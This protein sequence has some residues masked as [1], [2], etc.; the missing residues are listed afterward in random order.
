MKII[1]IVPDGVAVRNFL[2]SNFLDELQKKGFE[3]HVLYQIPEYAIKE[4]N[5]VTNAI[6]EYHR[7]PY[8]TE[9]ALARTLR[10]VGVYARLLHNKKVLHNETI[11]CFWN[12]KKKGF[13]R[14][15]LAKVSE[16]VGFFLSK[17]YSSILFLENY[18]V[19]IMA[20]TKIYNE[21][22]KIIKAINP[23]VVLNLHQRSITSSPI[24]NYCNANNIK[25]ATMIFSWDNVPKAR[26]IS[27]YK[28][29]F[30]WSELM[31]NELKITYNE[32]KDKQ[33]IVTGSPQFECYFDEKIKMTKDDFFKEYN[34]S[35]HKKTICFSSNDTSSPHEVN[36]FQDICEELDKL[37][38]HQKPQIVFRRN[39]VDKSNRFKDVLSKFKHLITEIEPDWKT[40]NEGDVH[41]NAV[42]PK[43]NDNRLLVNTVMFCDAVVNL[44]ST[45]AHDFAVLDKPC[46]YLNYNPVENSLFPVE[47]VYQ[48]Q[49]FRS[50]KG[51]DAVVWINNKSEISNKIIL[52]LNQPNE[53]AKDRKKWMERIIQHPLS[54]CSENIVGKL[55]KICTSV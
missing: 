12:N 49:H 19:K 6:K 27:R 8:F 25:T 24:I 2:Y 48:F 4:V 31:K 22:G 11:M 46:L 1:L 32:I 55:S 53:V 10:E 34:L 33:I 18:Y 21:V 54:Q 50:M 52:A 37:E 47:E 20:K 15:V 45:M 35:H 3:I 9:P 41:F 43:L 23:D 38:E 39:P 28:Y 7:I 40:E 14:K 51:L 5:E 16:T 17:S 42:F 30:T 26:L 29:Y 44:G 13:K 36:Y